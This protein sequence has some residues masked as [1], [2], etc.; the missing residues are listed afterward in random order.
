M[1]LVGAGLAAHRASD[2]YRAGVAAGLIALAA[3]PI[4]A[5]ALFAPADVFE[6]SC[7]SAP[8][9]QLVP[10]QANRTG[11]IEVAFTPRAPFATFEFHGSK[12]NMLSNWSQI[13]EQIK[14]HGA[15]GNC[16][17]NGF[18]YTRHPKASDI[19]ERTLDA[20]RPADV[21]PAVDRMRAENIVD[22]THRDMEFMEARQQAVLIDAADAKKYDRSFSSRRVIGAILFILDGHFLYA[23]RER[24][25]LYKW[26][27]REYSQEPID[28][29]FVTRE[30][31]SSAAIRA[32]L[33]GK[34]G[35]N[36][37]L[38]KTI[39]ASAALVGGAVTSQLGLR[40][41]S[42]PPPMISASGEGATE[43]RQ[44]AVSD[45]AG[46]SGI[47]LRTH[48]NFEG[49]R[50]NC[51]KYVTHW[52]VQDCY[53]KGSAILLASPAA[54]QVDRRGSEAY[55]IGAL[56]YPRADWDKAVVVRWDELLDEYVDAG[57]KEKSPADWICRTCLWEPHIQAGIRRALQPN[58]TA[59][60]DLNTLHYVTRDFPF[61]MDH[62]GAA[63]LLQKFPSDCVGLVPEGVDAFADKGFTPPISALA[64]QATDV[65]RVWAYQ[66]SDDGPSWG[67]MV[68][69]EPDTPELYVN[70]RIAATVQDDI[71]RRIRF[72][73]VHAVDTQGAAAAAEARRQQDERE[74]LA[75]KAAIDQAID[76]G[77]RGAVKVGTWLVVIAIPVMV[78][79]AVLSVKYMRA[80]RRRR[81][82]RRAAIA[83]AQSEYRTIDELAAEA[84]ARVAD[85]ARFRK[86]AAGT[87]KKLLEEARRR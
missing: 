79:I 55:V 52:D 68:I 33:L 23:K 58:F 40:E 80:R 73:E 45:G 25:H 29:S 38:P 60:R 8:I 17:S 53:E 44:P 69:I 54:K 83:H 10:I 81:A 32:R 84:E 63:Q 5:G 75:K 66:F 59:V 24:P 78:V 50:T 11:L 47:E 48:P 65:R 36:L 72:K 12:A 18:T 42:L 31:I 56:V 26:I 61:S 76:R 46:A 22:F 62:E 30:N 49:E 87:T 9:A 77:A 15:A 67:L 21:S 82:A 13:I 57:Y 3:L 70:A 27:G 71:S 85:A 64:C 28:V 41:T 14:S 7:G 19:M 20:M 37:P 34:L 1:A 4:R 35:A 86:R 2:L 51:S 6:I 74:R 16:A 39:P 43:P